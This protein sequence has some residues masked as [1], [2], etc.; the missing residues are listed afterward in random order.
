[1]PDDKV[2]PQPSL[3]QRLWRWCKYA[4]LAALLLVITAAVFHKP[5]ILWALNR[6]GPTGAAKAGLS[7]KWK[8]GGSVWSDLS[9]ESLEALGEDSALP[10]IKLSVGKAAVRYDLGAVWR[11]EYLKVARGI[12]L[13]DVTAVIDLRHPKPA[14][15]TQSAKP[16]DK[17]KVRDLMKQ[18]AWPD[19]DI[20]N[21]N[22]TVLLP[23]DTLTIS[24]L[25][26]DLP[27]GKPGTLR[28]KRVDHPQLAIYPV[29]DVSAVIRVA[30]ARID[31]E[32]LTLPPQVEVKHLGLDA[33]GYG[34]GKVAASLNMRSGAATAVV[35]ATADLSGERP[36]VD[37]VVDIADVD[38]QEVGR[39]LKGG[40]PVKGQLQRLHVVAKGDPMMPRALDAT[41]SVDLRNIA[42][43]EYRSEAVTL[44]ATLSGGK[45]H[46]SPLRVAA[47]GNHL[48]ATTQAD[49]PATWA[50]FAHTPL[51]IQWQLRAPTVQSIAGLPVKLS[52]QLNGEGTVSMAEQGLR[53]FSAKVSAA[54]LSLDANSLKSLEATAEGDLQSIAFK[55]IAQ[56]TAGDGKLDASGKIGLKPGTPSAVSWN[57]MLPKPEVLAK[58]LKLPWPTEVTLGEIGAVGDLAFDLAEVK[59][60][61][62]DAAKG[63][64]RI[65]VK[66]V[67]WR[68]APCELAS[69][70][71]SLAGGKASVAALD[72]QMPGN[73]RVHAEGS[74][75][76]GGAQSF[77]GILK[78]ALQDLPA[79]Q[80]WHDAAMKPQSSVAR[81]EVNSSLFPGDKIE[82]MPAPKM[83]RGGT[84]MIDWSGKGQ[85]KDTLQLEGTSVVK[86]DQVRYGPVPEPLSLDAAFSHDL[87]SA[88]F[89]SLTARYGPWMTAFDGTA[90]TTGVK[91]ENLIVSHDSK[92]LI[93]GRI[94][95]PLD[96]K[97]KPMPVDQT[98]PLHIHLATTDL[99]RL[100]ELASMAGKTLPDGLAGRVSATAQFD[101]LLPQLQAR[102]EVKAEALKLPDMPGGETGDVG[103]LLTLKEGQLNVDST[104]SAKPLEPLEIHG[105]AK[106]D[107]AALL[108]EPSAALDTPFE[109]S[110]K[111]DQPTLDFV[112]PLVPA[113]AELNGS[114][115]IDAR[116]EGTP[117]SPKVSGTVV[118]NA[119]TIAMHNQALPLIKDLRARITADGTTVKLESFHAV[120][121]GGEVSMSGT[122][123][124]K[125][126]TQPAFDLS[127]K[128]TDLLVIR[129]ERLSLRTDADLR[130]QGTPK[131]ARLSGTVDLTRGRVFQEVNFLPLTT[132]MNDLPPL[133]DAQVSKPVVDPSTSPLPPM[134][135]DWT[136][137]VNVRTKDSIRLLGNVLSGGVN[138]DLKAAGNGAV[139]EV[140]GL[141]E[142]QQ[143]SLRL[144]FSTLRVKTG[145]VIFERERPLEPVLELTAESTVDAYEIVLRGYGSALDPKLRFSST[146]PL[147]EGEIA[148]LLATGTTTAGIQKAGDE[149]AGRLLVYAVREAYR[150]TFQSRNKPHKLKDKDDESRF[151]VQERTE[152][153]RLGGVTGTYEFSRKMKVVGSTDP[154]GGFRAMLHYLFR[155]D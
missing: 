34:Q 15:S 109:A 146:P 107:I 20:R 131:A 23:V 38:D 149:A 58:S 44:E 92:K 62:F 41:V 53:Q 69:A 91:L 93:A 103:F 13:H 51:D 42:W 85:L 19:I 11:G 136:F 59:N 55:A 139:P 46:V 22:V 94:E 87:A 77:E 60:S 8:V 54:D 105:K 90:G 101:G 76:L 126:L 110:V 25:D 133:P 153:G 135:K 88:A 143:A 14:V 83:L 129:D 122:C 56:A 118:L 151:I 138:I 29:Q 48:E 78:V 43:Q 115:L 35:N 80:P 61:K 123:E 84:V 32:N 114:I 125:D 18:W 124:V 63:G 130:C 10:I 134:L 70:Q 45:V 121:A 132:L 64:G 1:M 112:K 24:G 73:N 99:H 33:S 127:L 81:E 86:I 97:A 116:A 17:Q 26:L 96:L 27:A 147:P 82:P 49:A 155:F 47:G 141:V 68:D 137:D 119:S 5:L 50:G 111:L 154:N 21:L 2:K 120:A 152:D 66:N 7:L 104:A 145:K 30:D 102:I 89:A 100:E 98:R 28:V 113:L 142:L 79:L 108:K 95:V 3:R 72:L 39:W 36:Q 6:F 140:T 67:T 150:R 128:A 9:F 4:L 144:P 16:A 40:L 71:W 31:I 37:A 74:M 148:A 117:R 57:L 75:A 52:G 12:T 65:T 106:V